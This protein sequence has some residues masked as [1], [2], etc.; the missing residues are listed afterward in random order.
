MGVSDDSFVMADSEP[1]YAV[2]SEP[3]SPRRANAPEQ[4]APRDR[5]GALEKT[6]AF[7]A[8]SDEAAR[9]LKMMRDMLH[10]RLIDESGEPIQA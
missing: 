6:K 3:S 8:A 2:A 1:G 4:A 7:M 9:R 10:G 5:R